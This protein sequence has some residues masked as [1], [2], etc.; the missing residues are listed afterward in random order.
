[1]TITY[2]VE[3]TVLWQWYYKIIKMIIYNNYR[4]KDLHH[5]LGHH[6]DKELSKECLHVRGEE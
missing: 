3:N 2:T 1:M 6:M 5:E 4:L